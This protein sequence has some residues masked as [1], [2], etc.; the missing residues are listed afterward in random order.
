MTEKSTRSFWRFGGSL[1]RLYN[2]LVGL[3]F[4]LSCFVQISRPI[5]RGRLPE[6]LG[7]ALGQTFWVAIVLFVV[8]KAIS[9]VR[10]R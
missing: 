10:K 7:A 1:D 3:F 5:Y 2:W 9:G 4:G 6:A 8:F